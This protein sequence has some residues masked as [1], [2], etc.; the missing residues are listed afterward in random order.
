MKD[1]RP[2]YKHKRTNWEASFYLVAF[3][4]GMIAY[5]YIPKDY[6][7]ADMPIISQ[8]AITGISYEGGC[9]RITEIHA[10]G[11]NLLPVSETECK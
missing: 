6:A 10:V 5:L 7:I 4:L 8:D 2:P 3:I 9:T 11:K 1:Y